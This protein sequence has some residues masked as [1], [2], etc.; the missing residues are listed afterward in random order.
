MVEVGAAEPVQ[1][2]LAESEI[3]EKAH[4]LELIGLH[5]AVAPHWEHL[6]YT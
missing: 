1:G 2:F 4:F 3:D 5:A 6:Q